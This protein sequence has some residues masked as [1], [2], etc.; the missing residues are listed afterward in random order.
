MMFNS[1]LKTQPLDPAVLQGIDKKPGNGRSTVPGTAPLTSFEMRADQLQTQPPAVGVP[2][3]G[4]SLSTPSALTSEEA[5]LLLAI[6]EKLGDLYKSDQDRFNLAMQ[7]LQSITA[8]GRVDFS[9]L[10]PQQQSLLAS[11]GLTA[12][13]TAQVYQQLYQLLLPTQQSQT[14]NAFQAVQSS[15]SHF[16]SNVDLRQ[17]TFS[18]IESQARDL[19]RIQGI[20][21]NLSASSI[22]SLLADQTAGVYDLAVSKITSQ[23]FNLQSGMD[24]TLGHFVVLSQESPATLQQVENVLKKVQSDQDITTQER[25]LLNR[26]GLNITAENKLETLDRKP[27]SL[28][29]VQQLE[30]VVF[31]MKDPSEGYARVLSASADVIRQSKKLEELGRRA[32]FEVAQV[33]QTTTE[34]QTQNQV[35]QQTHQ[36]TNQLNARLQAAQSQAQQLQTA[37]QSAPSLGTSAT[38]DISPLLLA[39]WNVRIERGPQGPN[40]YIGQRQV[41]QLE[42][43]SYLGNLLQQQQQV[44]QKM[45][46]DLARKK[47][48]ILKATADLAQTTRKLETQT[49]RLEQTRTEIQQETLRLQDLELIRLDL[50]RQET[51][52]LQP[53]ELELVR[54]V[55]DPLITATVKRVQARIQVLDAQM[56]QTLQLARETTVESLAT[57]ELVQRDARRWEQ[58]LAQAEDLDRSLSQTLT[59]FKKQQEK[60]PNSVKAEENEEK[61]QL[62]APPPTYRSPSLLSEQTDLDS[63][64][65]YQKQSEQRKAELSIQQSNS[66]RRRLDAIQD[67]EREMSRQTLKRTEQDKQLFQAEQ[68]RLK[69]EE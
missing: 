16:I 45:A 58:T 62:P 2:A 24:Y 57:Q 43:M 36:Q 6:S 64:A 3:Q 48:E 26:Y 28:Q 39:Q 56:E 10:T 27:L 44:I 61:I 41:S 29:E 20:V 68:Q 69:N 19:S 63:K 15:V 33:Q 67:E 4:V 42:L 66:E 52:H 7:A 14:S 51:P 12:E 1:H 8:Q 49:E 5:G 9:Q 47:S 50:I 54:T 18:Q 34:V 55:V 53:Q 13:N 38:V 31:S 46:T 25:Q 65:M 37:V 23:N 59:E 60:L 32:S 40:F 17:K 35:L 22:N 21:S 30:S 11:L